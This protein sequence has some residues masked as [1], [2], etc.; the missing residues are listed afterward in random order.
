MSWIFKILRFNVTFNVYWLQ[1]NRQAKYKDL[2]YVIMK[3][4][5]DKNE[6]PEKNIQG[7][8]QKMIL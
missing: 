5:I 3:N 1:T 8:P 7:Y 6:F 4:Y 2:I